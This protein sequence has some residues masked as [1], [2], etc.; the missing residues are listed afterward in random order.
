MYK[1]LTCSDYY[2]N[3]VAISD[4]QRPTLIAFEAF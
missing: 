4:I 3:S 1:P 2:G